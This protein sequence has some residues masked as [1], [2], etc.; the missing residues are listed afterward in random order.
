LTKALSNK[1]L[2]NQLTERFINIIDNLK[3]EQKLAKVTLK[4]TFH[5]SSFFFIFLHFSSLNLQTIY[6]L[7][8]KS[9]LEA[10][11]LLQVHFQTNSSIQP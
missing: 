5:F 11:F 10:V 3:L 6:L 7:K 4:L 1:T 9:N 2:A 8:Q